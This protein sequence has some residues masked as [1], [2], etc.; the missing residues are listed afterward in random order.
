[1]WHRQGISMDVEGLGLVRMS[2][3][4]SSEAEVEG[5]AGSVPRASFLPALLS[6]RTLC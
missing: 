4:G 6:R 3:P 1:M 5:K 2:W